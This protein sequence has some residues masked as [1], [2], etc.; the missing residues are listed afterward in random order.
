MRSPTFGTGLGILPVWCSRS[1][2]SS[3]PGSAA[4]LLR[5]G[6]ARPPIQARTGTAAAGAGPVSLDFVVLDRDGVPVADLTVDQVTLRV[7]GRARPLQSLRYVAVGDRRAGTGGVA[8]DPPYGTNVLTDQVQPGRA[9]VLVV[10]DESIEINRERLMREAVGLLLT[11]LAPHDRVA[12]VTVPHGG[13]RLDFTTD[14]AKAIR[15]FSEITGQAP[16]AESDADA[17]CRTRDTLNALTGLL[18]DLAGG[19][20]PTTVVFFSMGLVGPSEMVLPG[21]GAPGAATPV[22]GRCTLLPEAFTQTGTAA[23]AARAHFYIVRPDVAAPAAGRLEG[24]ENLAGVTGGTRLSLGG[25]GGGRARPG[26]ARDRRLLRG[27]VHARAER[28]RRLDPPCRRAGGAARRP[29]TGAI[30]R[31]DSKTTGRHR[32]HAGAGARSAA[33]RTRPARAAAARRRVSLA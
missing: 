7:D 14:H 20:G 22:I 27:D 8:A 19:E 33:R 17:A 26:R 30:G 18:D 11:S 12:V 31:P 4:A 5:R 2:S 32:R 10:E 9:L 21:R 6:A 1:G 15:V 29:G 23:G 13:L 28:A 25:A 24:I 3:Q 16:R